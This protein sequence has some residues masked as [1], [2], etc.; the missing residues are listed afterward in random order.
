MGREPRSGRTAVPSRSRRLC[1]WWEGSLGAPL[2]RSFSSSASRVVSLL[3]RGESGQVVSSTMGS[4]QHQVQLRLLLLSSQKPLSRHLAP[5]S[6][7]LQ[8]L[9]PMLIPMPIQVQ[10]QSQSRFPLQMRLLRG[11]Q[12]QNLSSPVGES[13]FLTEH[14][15]A[16]AVSGRRTA[17]MDSRLRR[18]V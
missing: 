12:N 18:K 2:R 7:L 15:A 4:E 17:L 1:G 10:A 5:F 16:I 3:L 9:I 6:C 13:D 8:V 11:S 14:R